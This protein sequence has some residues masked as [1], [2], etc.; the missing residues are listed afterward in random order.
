VWESDP[1]FLQEHAGALKTD[2]PATNLK[3][4]WR[5]SEIRCDPLRRK[6]G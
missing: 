6:T 1:N 5:Y 3:A 2:V 4:P